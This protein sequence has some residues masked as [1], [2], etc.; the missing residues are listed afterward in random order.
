M[1]RPVWL[2]ALLFLGACNEHPL[3]EVETV[4][5]KEW[6]AGARCSPPPTKVDVLL[7]VDDSPSMVEEADAVAQAMR[8]IGEVYEQTTLDY[9]VAV[10]S[11]HVSGPDCEP[12]NDGRFVQTSCVDRLENF[13]SPESHE[14]ASTDARASC[15]TTCEGTIAS[16]PWVERVEGEHNVD[17]PIRHLVCVGQVGFNGCEAE[18]PMAAALR[19]LERAADPA[20]PNFG[21]LRP[22]AGLSI[23]FLGDEDDCSRPADATE[24]LR[25]ATL[26]SA[27]WDAAARCDEDAC[28]PADAGDL[29]SLEAFTTRLRAI[30]ADKQARSGIVGQRVFVSA[31]GGVP[32]GYPDHPI[33]YETDESEFASAFGVAPGCVTEERVAAPPLRT[34]AASEA[35]AEWVVNIVSS[36]SDD[37]WWALACLPNPWESD[38]NAT[39]PI[40]DSPFSEF[41]DETVLS[42]SCIATVDGNLVVECENGGVPE[43]ADV[44]V[45][46]GQRE[47]GWEAAFQWSTARWGQTCV[48]VT[49]AEGV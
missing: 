34:L 9:R 17:D 44:C 39:L 23:V 49:C 1:S 19:A 18:S 25:G 38:W 45:R 42:E 40:D 20:D 10:T 33:R 36:C 30:E 46:W 16:V 28:E 43:G 27:C 48:E 11:T 5:V 47:S 35:F 12:G 14:A 8:D 21:F 7:V 13:I 4:R 3:A 6:V 2:V 29:L 22:D 32:V 41:V 37:W 24:P 26:S 15:R 31:V